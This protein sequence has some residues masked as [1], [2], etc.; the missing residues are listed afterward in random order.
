MKEWVK[1]LQKLQR[2]HCN[3]PREQ[4]GRSGQLRDKPSQPAAANITTAD[5]I[6]VCYGGEREPIESG[7]NTDL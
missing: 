2:E 7:Y 4:G 1:C 6:L 3:Q 5:L